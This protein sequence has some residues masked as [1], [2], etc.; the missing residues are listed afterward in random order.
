M[1]TTAQKLLATVLTPI[2]PVVALSFQAQRGAE[3]CTSQWT[4]GVN[5]GSG[6]SPSYYDACGDAPWGDSSG[7]STAP[8]TICDGCPLSSGTIVEVETGSCC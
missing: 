7:C 8:M 3:A 6:C 2:A 5:C 1:K 4:T